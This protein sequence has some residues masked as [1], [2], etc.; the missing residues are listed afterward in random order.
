MSTTSTAPASVDY[1]MCTQRVRSSGW[2][3]ARPCGRPATAE[4]GLCSPHRAGKR[5]SEAASAERAAYWDEE[6][7]ADRIERARA[8]FV[9]AWRAANPD[10]VSGIDW[11]CPLCNRVF[12]AA[13]TSP[14][15]AA[16]M[17]S[18]AEKHQRF[19]GADWAAFEA[20]EAR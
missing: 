1:G 20:L 5:R 2:P 15:Y 4:D 18:I 8:A 10:D 11:R 16:F 6:N 12:Q 14:D 3:P 17:R 7:R 19:H 13:E 9:K